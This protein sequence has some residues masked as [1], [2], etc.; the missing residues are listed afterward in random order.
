MAENEEV[1]AVQPEPGDAAGRGATATC[2]HCGAAVRNV[3]AEAGT[4]VLCLNCGKRFV[5]GQAKETEQGL[6]ARATS[7]V[8]RGAGYWLWRIP[9]LIACAGAV[10]AAGL[11]GYQLIWSF[12]RRGMSFRNE[13]FLALCYL[14]LLPWAGLVLVFLTRALAR[15]DAGAVRAAWRA[16]LITG[17]LPPP[18]GSSLPYIAPVAVAGGVL[19]AVVAFA[20][21]DDLEEALVAAAIGAGLFYLGFALEDLRHFVWRQACL[22]WQCCKP[23][24]GARPPDEL[25]GAP[26]CGCLLSGSG[27]LVA[28]AFLMFFC[29]APS[30][31]WGSRS[32]AVLLL[33]CAVASAGAAYS[34]YLL[35]WG[36]DNA[37]ANWSLAAP[38]R[39]AGEK[40]GLWWF[41]AVPFVWALGGW[42][43]VMLMCMRH[44]PPGRDAEGIAVFSIF[45]AVTVFTIWLGVFLWSVHRWREAQECFWRTRLG[46]KGVATVAPPSWHAWLTW[47]ARALV[48]VEVVVFAAFFIETELRGTPK[49]EELV[50][51]PLLLVALH[52]PTLWLA[53]LT[54]ELLALEHFHDAVRASLSP[55]E[56][57]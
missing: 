11:I 43:W 25:R 14:P 26:A 38:K 48:A 23:V 19:P 10:V 34:L 50:G 57:D 1:R 36:W 37:V 55:D 54:R 31:S 40:P 5:P 13:D 24:S 46:E 8:P 4:R 20:Q 53:F 39:P 35:G 44:G 30:R 2:P 27:A 16:G 45:G 42:F 51:F 28:L 12:R 56:E 52:Y 41:C 47:A 3:T 15:N 6:E 21:P 49:F 7:S 33:L 9:A 22:A 17:P 29:H 18:Q 32:E